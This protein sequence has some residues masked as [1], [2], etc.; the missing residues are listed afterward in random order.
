MK[1]KIALFAAVALITAALFS[2]LAFADFGDYAGDSDWG[3]GSDWGG[4]DWGGSDY[5]YDWGSDY[6]YGYS[7]SS[8]GGSI[9]GGVAVVVVLVIVVL[10]LSSLKAKFGHQK[11][12]YQS[13]R[14]SVNIENSAPPLINDL[15]DLKRRD[16]GFNESK[17]LEDGA[18]LYVRMQ[19]AW[20]NKDLSP[21]ETRLTA[22]L[23]AK[24]KRQLE[25]YIRGMRTNHIERIS[26]LSSKIAGCTKDDKND[27]LTLEF[28][29]RI[30]DYVTDDRNG[31]LLRGDPGRELFMTYRWTFIRTLGRVTAA[32][33][34]TDE[35]QCPSCGAPLNLNQSAVCEYCGSVV[36]SGN[37]DW[38]LSNIQG[39][40]Q[41]S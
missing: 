29:A 6:D 8:G 28:T 23:Y 32:A 17:F 19:N 5:D 7:G 12:R 4:S 22:E 37:Y 9:G 20:T 33:G 39:I 21:V 10:V 34:E 41:R 36:E 31:K 14:R 26:V 3:G 40:S 30:V 38:V 2:T 24:S 16:P 27:I 35:R 25:S 15:A 13:S 11:P 18:N 1:R